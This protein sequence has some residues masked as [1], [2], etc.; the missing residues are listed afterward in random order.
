MLKTLAS[1]VREYKSYAVKAPLYVSMEVILE[2]IIPLIMA[3]LIDD[4]EKGSSP[5]K[6]AAYAVI[7]IVMALLS[8][9]C[10]VMS[11]RAAATAGCG[12]AKNLRKDLY[13]KVQN[14]AF[15]DI[16]KF[17]TSSLVTRLTTDVTN[18][19]Q[20]FQMIIRIAVRTPLMIIVSVVMSFT[21]NAK[22]ACI[23]LVA[24]PILGC[25]LIGIARFVM[26]I[27]K[28]I[29]KQYD[30]LN[31]SV[32]ENIAGIRVV[33]SFVR[34]GY[35]QEKFGKASDDVRA[36]FTRVEKILA[37]NN[38]I[39]MFC[40]NV[41]MILVIFLGSQM[42]VNTNSTELSTGQLSQLI[43]YGVQVLSSLMMLSMV[44]VMTTMASESANR[45]VEVL[46]HDSSLKS[47]VNGATE[48]ADGSITLRRARRQHYQT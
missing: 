21:I 36:S 17:S 25:A 42:V 1:K 15:A 46:N 33:K 12:F 14:F 4:M 22:M 18:V 16:D 30:A 10:G 24:A 13:Y 38:P 8:L 40:M 39:M 29:F 23:F 5:S 27:F 45:I 6:I 19:Q 2:C 32:Q 9:L 26:P 34:E 7:L 37:L 44:F 20:A 47:P 28:R 35:E 31:N 48:L 43:T 11:A 3:S 41:T